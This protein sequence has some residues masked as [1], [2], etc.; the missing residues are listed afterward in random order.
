MSILNDQGQEPENAMAA[1]T[2]IINETRMTYRAFLEAFNGGARFFWRN[3][4][5]SPGE[6]AAALGSD[7]KEVFELHARLGA[8]LAAIEP[9]LIQQGLSVVGTVAYHEDGTVT[10]TEPQ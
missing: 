9:G 3:D 5:A 6:I 4:L 8:F 2:R 10:V 7:A 1:A